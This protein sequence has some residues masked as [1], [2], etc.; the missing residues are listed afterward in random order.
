MDRAGLSLACDL[1]VAAASLSNATDACAVFVRCNQDL[2]HVSCPGTT[3][4]PLTTT[5]IQAQARNI[6]F[7]ASIQYRTFARPILYR[8]VFSCASIQYRIVASPILYGSAFFGSPY[9]IGSLLDLY[10]ME[11]YF[12]M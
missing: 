3:L 8:G 5:K 7:G 12:S 11:A 1:R 4:S 10:C 9:N 6:F 2:L